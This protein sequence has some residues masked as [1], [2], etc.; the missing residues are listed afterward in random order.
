MAGGPALACVLCLLAAELDTKFVQVRP[1]PAD[2]A[3]IERS[4]GQQRAVVLVPGLWLHPFSNDN[5]KVAHFQDWQKPQAKLVEVLAEEAD[6]FAFTYSQNCAVWDIAGVP[7][8][9]DAIRRLR[10]AGYTEIVLLGHSAGGLIARQFVEDH[11][12][13]G[14]TKVIQVCSPN[15]GAGLGSLYRSVRQDQEPFI[16][17]MTKTACRE[18]WQSRTD[19]KVPAAVQF[20]CVVAVAGDIGKAGD[21]V[22]SDESQWPEDLQQQG[23][24]AVRLRTTHFTAVRS[25]RVAERLAELVREPQPRVDAKRIAVLRKDVFGD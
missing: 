25:R 11:P 19:K 3:K 7:A 14:V 20:V 18:F 15:S 6:I 9:G 2:A 24:A 12:D 23:V 22:V 17:S 1:A 4:D 5:V 10:S 16:Q 13:A 21:G 8:L